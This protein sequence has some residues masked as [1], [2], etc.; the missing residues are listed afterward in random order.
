MGYPHNDGEDD[1][2]RAIARY[3]RSHPDLFG[4]RAFCRELGLFRR[5]AFHEEIAKEAERNGVQHSALFLLWR[6][7]PFARPFALA[8]D[9]VRLA[10]LAELPQGD[11]RPVSDSLTPYLSGLAM[12]FCRRGRAESERGEILREVYDKR[13]GV[14][15][16]YESEASNRFGILRFDSAEDACAWIDGAAPI[17]DSRK[18]TLAA[19]RYYEAQNLRKF[20]IVSARI[21]QASEARFGFGG[22]TVHHLW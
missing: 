8:S 14:H 21:E 2:R 19:R 1:V 5:A 18:E 16:A 20:G 4:R 17:F 7:W 9:I 11:H 15:L 12:G 3:A 6:V 10:L 22:E 13:Y